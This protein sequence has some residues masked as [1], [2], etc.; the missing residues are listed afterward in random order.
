M[1][2]FLSVAFAA[3]ILLASSFAFAAA[4]TS[5]FAPTMAFDPSALLLGT[6][7]LLLLAY[8]LLP[9]VFRVL[10]LALIGVVAAS[11]AC[12]AAYADTTIAVGDIWSGVLPYIVAAIGA[13][14]TFLVGWVLNLL[15]TKLGVSIDDS[16]RASLQTAAT[17]AA[18][19]V[20]NQLGNQLS[21]TKIDVGNQFVA[22]AV[23]Y[24]LKAAPDAVAH[25]GL[26]PDAIAQKILALLPQVANTTT[27]ATAPSA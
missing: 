22:D 16:M 21:G 12:N 3:P 4:T 20:L 10:N 13:V 17:N 24:V 8:R 11:L 25:F 23:N 27:T 1:N 18:G 14:I 19:L 15:K 2:R 7:V 6:M 5:A 26:T 9:H